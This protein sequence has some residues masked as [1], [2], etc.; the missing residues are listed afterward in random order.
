MNRILALLLLSLIAGACT[1]YKEYPIEIYK[2]GIIA[3]PPEADNVVIV[4]RNFKYSSDTLFH[5]L[6]KDFQLKKA[7]GD[8]ETLD[9]MLVNL[10]MKELGKN[11]KYNNTF[12]EIH[13]I[14]ELFK[15]HSGEKLPAL[16]YNI[17]D[18]IAAA[19]NS[20]LLI[21]LETFSCFYSE[22]PASEQIPGE[23][24][25]VVTVAVWAV[26][27][28]RTQDLIER[29]TMIDTVLWSDYNN[30]NANFRHNNQLPSRITALQIAAQMAGENYSKR[31][32]ASWETA[33]RLY[34]IPPLPDFA[35]ADKLVQQEKWDDAIVLWRRYADDSNGKMAINAR[36][37]LALAYEMKDELDSARKWLESAQQIASDYRSKND[38]EMIRHYQ[39]LLT[40]RQNDILKLNPIE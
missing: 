21:S 37:N 6:Q 7:S 13:V 35:A 20:D 16:D 4:S 18:K 9:S 24:N 22:Y 8:P 17:T 19:T 15:R 27:N 23:S 5:H 12:N 33:N 10:S 1:V 38:L 25:E 14:P 32:T 26:Y 2:P 11:L 36:Y 39:K 29:K 3:V 34:S 30:S 40:E 28:P 31:F